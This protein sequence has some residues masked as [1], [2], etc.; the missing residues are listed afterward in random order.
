MFAILHPLLLLLATGLSGYLHFGYVDPRLKIYAIIGEIQLFLLFVTVGTAIFMKHPWL[1]TRWRK[2][3]LLNYVIFVLVWIHSWFLGSDV[4]TSNLKYLWMFYAVTVGLSVVWRVAGQ[5]VLKQIKKLTPKNMPELNFVPVAKTSDIKEGAPFC[6]QAN[7]KQIAL[8]KMGEKF[9]AMDNLCTHAGGPLCE[10]S[11]AGNAI[12]CPWHG[13]QFDI[14][15]GQ[16]LAGPAAEPQTMY[17]VK[18]EGEDVKV[19]V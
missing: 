9:Y 7:G 19:K 18:V 1:R 17:E 11:L 10:G 16:V 2:I 14:T 12:E 5:R 6:A 15:T 8:F 3:H 13:S 4:Q